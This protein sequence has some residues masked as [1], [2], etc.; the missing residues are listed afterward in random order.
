M[1]VFV[2]SVH[3]FNYFRKL[4]HLWLV[5]GSRNVFSSC[6]SHMCTGTR[7]I[8]RFR[9]LLFEIFTSIKILYYIVAPSEHTNWTKFWL[10]RRQNIGCTLSGCQCNL[11]L[12]TSKII[13]YTTFNWIFSRLF[14]THTI[15]VGENSYR[16]NGKFYQ[17]LW[18]T[19]RPRYK[20]P[21]ILNMYKIVSPEMQFI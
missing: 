4:S 6:N 14:S 17:L 9:K 1:F 20:I 13:D 3:I 7:T 8:L 5:L 2:D 10:I 19:P 21:N 11:A 18:Y 12:E 16:T 15:L